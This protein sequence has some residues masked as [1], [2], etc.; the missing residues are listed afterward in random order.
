RL[1]QD[2]R[3]PDYA[4]FADLVRSAK[5]YIRHDSQLSSLAQARAGDFV[6]RDKNF[7]T[8]LP[9]RARWLTDPGITVINDNTA[10]DLP[11]QRR[12]ENFGFART[13][14]YRERFGIDQQ[15]TID[16]V[17]ALYAAPSTAEN[18]SDI[19]RAK[20]RLF[21][22]PNPEKGYD[23]ISLSAVTQS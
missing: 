18:V 12:I 20:L 22:G 3:D 14:W 15:P 9:N 8:T 10:D 16:D 23:L 11:R 21:G 6:I 13:E 7:I 17:K 5:L 1:L 2:S 4:A 19:E